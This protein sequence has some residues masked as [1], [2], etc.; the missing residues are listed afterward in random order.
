MREGLHRDKPK[1][2]EEFERVES[3]FVYFGD[4]SARFVRPEFDPELDIENR[5]QALRELVDLG[6]PR[7]FRRRNCDA[8][9]GKSAVK[10][11]LMD[12]GSSVGLGKLLIKQKLPELDDYLSGA[13]W[14]VEVRERLA[15]S[16]AT[17]FDNQE[18]VMIVGHCLGS[19]IAYDTLWQMSR[20]HN[21]SDRVSYFVT[22]GSPLGDNNVR[23]LLLGRGHTSVGQYPN[24]LIRWYN[25]SAEDDYVCHDKAV[26]DDFKAMLEHRML[27]EIGDQ[28]IYNLTVRYGRS[29]P[30]S[31]VGYLIHPR[32]SGI[33]SDWLAE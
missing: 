21:L 14:G 30:H 23:S 32:M 6:K 8:L 10:E 12:A 1:L 9:P 27:S 3:D 19:V 28:T 13:D 26:G 5:R 2:V 7:E 18:E 24:N 31:S 11:F 4:H 22:L 16:L 33:L 20:E 15:G 17:A 29:N 25:L